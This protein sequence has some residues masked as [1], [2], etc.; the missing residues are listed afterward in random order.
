MDDAAAGGPP[1]S[2]HEDW[3][4]PDGAAADGCAARDLV[5][6]YPGPAFLLDPD[7]GLASTSFAGLGLV[8]G[9]AHA[10]WWRD[11]QA[12]LGD[13][14][15]GAPPQFSSSIPVD[16]GSIIVEWLAVFLADGKTALLGREVTAE[17]HLRGALAESRQRFRDL[18]ELASDF[19]W[20]TDAEG[21]FVYVS[22]AGALGYAAAELVDRPA[23]R[24]LVMD[25]SLMGLPFVARRPF[26]ETELWLRRADDEIAT[27]VVWARPILSDDDEWL[28]ARGLCRDVT[29]DRQ[30][31]MALAD[32]RMRERVI[33]H[34]VHEMRDA[35][36][37]R[38]GLE[39]AVQGTAHAVGASGCALLADGDA[40]P[41]HSP[42]VYA[43]DDSDAAA[44]LAALTA[45]GLARRALSQQDPVVDADDSL[46]AMAVATRYGPA[47]N[48]VLVLWRATERG[49][50]LKGDDVLARL[51]G[52]QLGIGLANAGML[53]RLR[54]QA[55][56]DGLTGLYNRSAMLAQMA[57]CLRDPHERQSA[58]LYID[59]DHFKAVNDR[60]GHRRGDSV[61]VAMGDLLAGVIAA[62]DLA[63]RMGGDEFVVWLKTADD[64]RVGAVANA[65]VEG[66]RRLVRDSDLD[67]IDFGVSI[68][69]VR[70]T[71]PT[72]EPLD[73]IINRADATMYCAKGSSRETGSR[74]A[75]Q[76]AG[77]E[78]KE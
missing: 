62:G 72:D 4:T 41:G 71:S 30:R 1:M 32:A 33:A 52:D 59:L 9:L 63:G 17:R 42:I 26:N 38:K 13:A 47:A 70:V 56:R 54:H 50:W 77:Q 12:W 28:G 69:V 37:P 6:R 64:A 67:S 25:E 44:T 15:Q 73:A 75:W 21:R 76:A 23:E 51:M 74:G 46:L 19:A 68:G 45:D 57:E 20:E 48:G 66:G 61:L 49:P 14:R 16:R 55:E 3:K 65:I 58:L 39:Q 18:V 78:A 8:P 11:I 36:D 7:G 43:A 2:G 5:S 40:L 24:L 22:P 31:D 10:D 27:V 53:E 60:F 34:I 29:E 35:T